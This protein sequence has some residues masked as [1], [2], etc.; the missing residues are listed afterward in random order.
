[1]SACG[2]AG[3]IAR[4]I[5]TLL[6]PFP[7]R[8]GAWPARCPRRL[9]AGSAAVGVDLGDHRGGDVQR[10]VRQQHAVLVEDRLRPVTV[11][12]HHQDRRDPSV[13]LPAP[14]VKLLGQ[15]RG[16]GVLVAPGLRRRGRRTRRRAGG[17]R[18]GRASGAARSAGAPRPRRPQSSARASVRSASRSRSSSASSAWPASEP[19]RICSWLMIRN[20]A[21]PPPP[22]TGRPR[23]RSAATRTAAARTGAAREHGSEPGLDREAEALELRR[24]PRT[25]AAPRS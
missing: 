23:R 24:S 6:R 21:A 14:L 22:A 18:R 19:V 16:P 12:Q 20:A 17:T 2:S 25:G 7:R 4:A 1:M 11:H 5:A 3:S 9:G 10:L 15:R 13:E 8:G